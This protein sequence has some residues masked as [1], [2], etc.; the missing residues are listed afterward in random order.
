M[1]NYSKVSTKQR[2]YKNSATYHIKKSKLF[3]SVQRIQASIYEQL[4]KASELHPSMQQTQASFYEEPADSRVDSEH[5]R[6]AG[7]DYRGFP[8]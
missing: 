4:P 1:E 6:A 8:E 2:T 7:G 3:P 5:F